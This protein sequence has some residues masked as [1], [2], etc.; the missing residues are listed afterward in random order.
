MQSGRGRW[1]SCGSDAG[2]GRHVNHGG[3]GLSG[4]ASG[5]VTTFVCVSLHPFS[6]GCCTMAPLSSCCSGEQP[7]VLSTLPFCLVPLFGMRCFRSRRILWL[8]SFSD[9]FLLPR[10]G[11]VASGLGLR[12]RVL[13][14]PASPLVSKAGLASWPHVLCVKGTACGLLPL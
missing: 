7:P 5:C 9:G 12:L 10:N 13:H 3:K 14:W 11:R 6:G 1:Q 8:L 2:T 4:S